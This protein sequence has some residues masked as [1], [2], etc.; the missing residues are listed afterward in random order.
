M[1][2]RKTL[3]TIGLLGALATLAP[4]DGVAGGPTRGTGSRGY[5]SHSTRAYP[6]P[7][8]YRPY[9]Y[10]AYS[11]WPYYYRPYAYLPYVYYYPPLAFST[12]PAYVV[13]APG[14]YSYSLPPGAYSMPAA[15]QVEREVAFPE[16]R[17][18]LQGDGDAVPYRWVWV[19]NPPAAPPAPAQDPR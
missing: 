15:P 2:P 14:A 17:Y 8:Y 7:Y 13:T 4:T 5:S 6:Y 3:A 11:Y 12:P 16:G 10:R 1:A 9:Y 18:L 19:P